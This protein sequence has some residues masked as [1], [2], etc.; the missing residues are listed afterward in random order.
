MNDSGMN[1]NMHIKSN[2][3]TFH[4]RVDGERGATMGNRSAIFG[5]PRWCCVE[6]GPRRATGEHAADACYDRGITVTRERT[7]RTQLEHRE[8][9]DLEYRDGE[10][11][12]S[13]EQGG[14]SPSPRRE[15]WAHQVA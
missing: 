6:R 10:A 15:R 3:S 13:V 11:V 12:R 14:A 8:A 9:D 4:C 2:E 7:G 5:T 1:C